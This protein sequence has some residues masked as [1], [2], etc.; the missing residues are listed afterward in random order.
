MSDKRKYLL[1]YLKTGG[2]H[3][4]PAKAIHNYI[5]SHHSDKV[6]TNLIYGFEKTPR[7]VRYV[8]EDGYRILQ[9]KGR[10]FFEFLY[11]LNK[12]PMIARMSCYSVAGYMKNYLEEII[13]RN[14]ICGFKILK[15]VTFH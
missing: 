13:L 3:L 6:E 7:W 8:I 14:W 10:W 4:A 1:A 15:V 11:A 12:I 2:G 5:S 9:Y